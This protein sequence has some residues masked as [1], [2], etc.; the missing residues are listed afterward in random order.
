M[1]H[2][3]MILAGGKSSRMGQDKANLPWYQHTL[4]QH[5]QQRLHASLCKHVLIS[6]NHSQGIHDRFFNKGPLG[7]IDA[8]LQQLPEHCLL[9]VTPVDMPLLDSASLIRLQTYSANTLHSVSY[10]HSFLPCVIVVTES[11]KQYVEEQLTHGADYSIK[12]MLAFANAESIS[13][14]EPHKLCNTNTPQQW[15]DVINAQSQH[16]THRAR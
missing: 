2:I 15:H 13:H 6:R 7:G 12:S 3:G 10:S 5:M 16:V 4:L 1:Q 14:P 9:T 11:L 8:V